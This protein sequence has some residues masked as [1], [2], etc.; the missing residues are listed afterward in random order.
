MSDIQL[1][2]ATIDDAGAV[3]AVHVASWQAA[4]AGIIPADYL[5]GLSVQNREMVWRAIIA[6]KETETVLAKDHG[7][8]I[9]WINFGACRDKDLSENIEITAGEILAL[10]VLASHWSQGVGRQ[11]WLHACERLY[12]HGFTQVSLWVLTENVRAIRFYKAVG[13]RPDSTS[14]RHIERGGRVLHEQRYVF[15]PSST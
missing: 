7:D 3:A 10:Y 11:L 9:G 2:P 13:F 14:Q 8:I 1:V 6:K 12:A 15:V 4:Y 5:A